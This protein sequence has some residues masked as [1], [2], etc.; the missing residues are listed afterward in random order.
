MKGTLLIGMCCLALVLTVSTEGWSQN[1]AELGFEAGA[2]ET[3]M[4]MGWNQ[5]G[6]YLE[7]SLTVLQDA[8]KAHT[9]TGVCELRATAGSLDGT[10]VYVI[11]QRGATQSENLDD[12]FPA[13]ATLTMEAWYNVTGFDPPTTQ[14]QPWIYQYNNAV[15]LLSYTKGNDIRSESNGAGW[16]KVSH[17]ITVN[18]DANG[19]PFD[20]EKTATID[21]RPVHGYFYEHTNTDGQDAVLLIDDISVTV[22]GLAGMDEDWS[23]YE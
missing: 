18:A 19:E 23:L 16:I 21:L 9:G 3:G 13:G 15:Q 7:G 22:S 10:Q 17:S 8:I 1:A 20:P 11:R 5:S 2:T 12:I 14:A 6:V 4:P